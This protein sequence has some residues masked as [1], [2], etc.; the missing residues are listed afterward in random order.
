[1][2]K[3]IQIEQNELKKKLQRTWSRNKKLMEIYN[4]WVY[5]MYFV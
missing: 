2:A 3:S 1:M 5:V 4:S